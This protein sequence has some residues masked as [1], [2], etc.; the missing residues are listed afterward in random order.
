MRA[1][2]GKTWLCGACNRPY[3]FNDH[4]KMMADACCLCRICGENQA[5]YVGTSH[6]LCDDCRAA[7]KLKVAEE[8]HKRALDRLNALKVR[9]R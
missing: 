9:S 8:E 5:L 1:I 2:E 3:P 6:S 7:E 4:G